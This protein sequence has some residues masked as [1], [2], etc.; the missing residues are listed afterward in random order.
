MS[1]KGILE[2]ENRTENWKTARY[3]SPFFED[4]AAGIRLAKRLGAPQSTE[5]S[6]VQLELFWKGMRDYVHQGERN[7]REFSQNLVLQRRL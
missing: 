4:E 1:N 6:E 5:Q 3:F 7:T 2:I